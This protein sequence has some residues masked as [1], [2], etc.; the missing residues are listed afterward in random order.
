MMRHACRR[1]LLLLLSS[2]MSLAAQTPSSPRVRLSLN[3][4]WRFF[5]GDVAGA[6]APAFD[7]AAW[8]RV[9]LPHTWNASDA[10]R[11]EPEYRRGA[12]WYRRRLEVT[13]AMTGKRLFLYFEG[14]NQVADVWVNGKSAG[15]HV[16]GYTAFAMDVTDLVVPGTNVVAVRVDNSFD[17]DIPPLSADFTFYGGLYRNVWLLAT[18]PLHVTV[19]DH[20]SPGVF[21]DVP[22]LAS[23][24]AAVRVRGTIANDGAAKR[25]A[26]VV[27]RVVDGDGGEVATASFDVPV[28]PRATAAF[29][30]TLP[31]ITAPRLWSPDEPN[32][33]T[34][35]T[36]VLD[37][38]RL[39]DRVD[40]PLGLRWYAWDAQKGFSLNGKPYQLHGTNRHQ[41]VRG[42]G[43][44]LPDALQRRDVAL[45]KS[46][47][48]DFLRLAHYPQAPAV[49]D[50]ADRTGVA[51][52][53]EI[54]VVNTITMSEAFAANAERMVTE[55]VKQHYDHPSVLFWGY[56]NEIMLVPPKPMPAG[57]V[58]AVV[59]LAKRLNARVKAEDTTRPTVM[60][61]FGH[62]TTSALHAVPDILGLNL[63]F[64]WYYG[65]LPDF[66][67][68]VDSLHAAYPGKPLMI[69]EYGAGDDER[70]HAASP[71]R[72][73]FSTEY[74]Q[75]YHE[76]TFPQVLARPWLLGSALWNQFDFGS[77]NRNDVQPMVNDK[78]LFYFDRRPK[79]VAYYYMARLRRDPVLHIAVRDWPA[80]AGS[81]P[82][83]RTTEVVVYSNA[84][85]AS[86]A[87]DGTALGERPVQNGRASWEVILHDGEN[88][89][90]ARASFQG[91]EL[92]DAAVVRYRDRSTLFARPDVSPA[93]APAAAPS[94]PGTAFRF[95]PAA[96]IAVNVGATWQFIDRAGVT[97]EP[98]RAYTPGSWGWVGGGA[99]A[100]T[101]HRIYDT[102]DDPLLQTA[103]EG[104]AAWR[105][106]V[107]DGRYEVE[108]RFVETL[109]DN[110]GE[111]V[112]DVDVNGLTLAERLDLAA[113]PGRWHART[114][115]V[116]VDAADGH[117]IVA[118][119]SARAGTTT[120]SAIRVTRR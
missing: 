99:P 115:V 11:K 7:D 36:E 45:V 75:R 21:G 39:A 49:L 2:S 12:G 116:E 71:R 9:D 103:R 33:Y 20:A 100:S 47:G 84:S 4:G 112:F 18:D 50:E 91:R 102:A 1:V 38:A 92:T 59:A 68:Y 101:N 64:G 62:D 66:G 74:E 80:R 28:G 17:P 86:L 26:R 114:V 90:E 110:P 31:P 119:L 46:T 22:A 48:F 65:A 30:R 41:D 76:G 25:T 15:R 77:W 63:Y 105:F 67:A 42:L 97:W 40:A 53:E 108:L 109:H 69:S 24:R 37:G 79:D 5:A 8:A 96:E 70:I 14:A 81:T 94:A 117:G 120:I 35:R 52:W 118:K 29:Q 56:M 58:D 10:L 3:E 57:Y 34:L 55:M 88:R 83:D 78:G 19:L 44:A 23:G 98:D 6:D 106:D 51:L 85:S 72:L 16:G 61:V 32:L 107:P 104:A 54:P 13:P 43:N 113:V 89:L 60:A 73:D 82:A 95:P 87:L 27:T 93:T 111:R